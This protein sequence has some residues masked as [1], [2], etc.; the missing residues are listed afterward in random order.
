M[1]V[2]ANL[3]RV[4]RAGLPGAFWCASP[5][6]S[7]A[8]AF[9]RSVPCF[10]YLF[11]VCAPVVSRF[12]WFP[13]PGALGLGAVLCV[14]VFFHPASRLSVRSRFFSFFP[15][16]PLAAPWCFVPPP[17]FL[18]VWLVLLLPLGV[19]PPFFPLRAPLLSF[20]FSGFW[21]R[22]PW[23]LALC[24]VCFVGL[25]LLGSSC[26]LS[27]FCVSPGRWLLPRGCCPPP[28]LPLDAPFF[29]FFRVVRPR[30]LR[31]SLV[32]GPG[33]LGPQRCALFALLASRSSASRAFWPLSRLP[34]GRWLLP[35]GCCPPPPFCVSLFLSLQLGAVSRVLC[36]AV[37]PRV[38]C[39]AALLRVVSPGVVLLCALVF[40]CARSVPLLVM[41]C[42]LVLPVA[43]G[44]C[45]LR[46][47][48]LRCSPALCV[49]CRC[50]VM[51]AVARRSALWCVCPWQLCCAFPVLPALCSA[52]GGAQGPRGA[53]RAWREGRG[54][55]RPRSQTSSAC[56]ASPP[57]LNKCRRTTPSTTATTT[58][59]FT[60][61]T[62]T[63]RT[64]YPPNPPDPHFSQPS[65]RT[66]APRAARPPRHQ[67]R[68]RSQRGLPLPRWRGDMVRRQ[69]RRRTSRM[70]SQHGGQRGP[71]TGTVTG[72]RSRT[73]WGARP[74]LW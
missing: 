44:P 68:G 31:L 46:R 42:A 41:P 15:A 61:S 30:S 69:R 72:K 63:R 14:F 58:R 71:E 1:R 8:L 26:G 70:Q 11:F 18:C 53:G 20:A 10:F 25:P 55:G 17:P 3:G 60:T 21:P 7:A 40:C 57:V 35:G 37:C 24:F 54:A 43:I 32:S 13:A 64:S 5:F 52:R 22:V 48:V 4:G 67:S 62:P 73:S 49:F 2:L 51:C 50:V 38:R 19:P 29:C 36:S 39:C 16:S 33:C 28:P 34:S 12:L 47:S 27:F 59:T 45:V 9:C 66:A 65:I 23:A 74:S 6:P 56:G